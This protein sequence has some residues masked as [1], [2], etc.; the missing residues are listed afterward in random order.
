VQAAGLGERVVFT[1]RVP[2]AEVQR[3]YELIDLLAY[4]RLP[5]RLTELVTPLKPLEAMAQGRVFV[6]SDVGGHRELVRH[7]ETGYLCPAGDAAALATAIDAALKR[8]RRVACPAAAGP[9]V[10]RAG[11][12]LGQQR[13]T[14]RRG[15]PQGAR[16]SRPAAAHGPERLNGARGMCGIHGLLHLDGTAVQPQWLTAMGDVTA[17]A[18]PTTKAS[19]STATAASRCGACP[20]ST[21][22]AVTS[23]S[24]TADGR[25]TIVCNGEIYNYRE[26]RQELEALGHRFKTGSDSETLLHGY[27]AWGDEVVHRLNGMFDFALWD[28]QRRRL[29]IG[30]DRLGVKPLYVLQDGRR[31]AFA[32]EA[33]ALLKLPGVRAELDHDCAGRLPAPGLR[34]GA[35]QIFRGIRKLPPATCWRWK[36]ARCASGAGGACPPMWTAP[37]EAEWVERVR[38][39]ID[40][41][42]RMQMVS[43][44]PI[45][46]FLSGGVDSSASSRHGA[47]QR[48]SADPHL[49]DRLRGRRGRAALQRAALRPP[50]GRACSAPTTTR[51]SCKPDVVGLLP[52]LVWHM[53]EPIADSAFI[54]TYLVSSSR[55]RTSRSSSPASAA[56][57]SSAATGATWA[58]TTR[59]ATT[60]M[61]GWAR[62]VARAA[63]PAAAG[64]RHSRLLNIDAA[65]QGLRGQR[66]AAADDRYRSYLQVLARERGH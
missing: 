51:S 43:D 18:A 33:K 25:L 52:K 46:A 57:S 9:P 13:R 32:T 4:P 36:T 63:A 31:L 58:A 3:Y 23:P 41:S 34:A 16:R 5:I 40:R 60:A 7:G 10:R 20:S 27:A 55:G 24:A 1:G 54:T 59:S 35:A 48:W 29:L 66:R 6:A 61:P 49:R 45:G 11:A 12:H 37:T 14:L 53:D 65:G 50:G 47:P 2:H 30:R 19:T 44:V 15:L 64:D 38:D 28:A 17:T 26:L 56:T 22:P 8:Q 39:G 21:W 62:S 42:V